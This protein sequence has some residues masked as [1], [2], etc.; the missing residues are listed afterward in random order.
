[1]FRWR[2]LTLCLWALML[3]CSGISYAHGT[4]IEGHIEKRVEGRMVGRIMGGPYQQTAPP[5]VVP[6]DLP[7][8]RTNALTRVEAFWDVDPGMGMATLLP[9]TDGIYDNPI[10]GFAASLPAPSDPGV[11]YLYIRTIEADNFS[12]IQ[13]YPIE[14]E[15]PLVGRSNRLELAECF[16][17]FDPGFGLG[18]PLTAQDGAMDGALE[19]LMGN[20]PITLAAGP[21]ILYIRTKDEAGNW[22]ATQSYSIE[23]DDALVGR[24]NRL[25]A[26]EYT[27]NLFTTGTVVAN[28]GSFSDPFELLTASGITAPST[29]GQYS[30]YVRTQD[31]EGNWSSYVQI[32]IMV[33]EPLTARTNRLAAAQYTWDQFN[34]GTVVANDGTFDDPLELI[35]ASGITA[36]NFS[37]QHILYVRTQDAEGTWSPYIRIPV[38]T[39]PPLPPALNNPVT[40]IA[41]SWDNYPM[42]GGGTTIQTGTTNLTDIAGT[43]STSGLSPG[44]HLLYVWAEDGLTPVPRMHFVLTPVYVEPPLPAARG[45]TITKVTAFWDTD[46]G[47]NN[48]SLVLP[49][50]S[51]TAL[52]N[53][54]WSGLPLPTAPGFHRLYVRVYN[55]DG[56]A[57]TISQPVHI[58]PP[59]PAARTNNLVSAAYYWDTD[60]TVGSPIPAGTTTFADPFAFNFSAPTTGLTPGDHKLYI[61]VTDADGRSRV[62]TQVVEID[63]EEMMMVCQNVSADNI[64]WC[65]T[66]PVS[67][68]TGIH[69]TGNRDGY[70]FGTFGGLNTST[71]TF[72][73]ARSFHASEEVHVTLKNLTSSTGG[74]MLPSGTYKHYIPANV[75]PATFLTTATGLT[76]Q[77][78]FTTIKVGDLDADGDADLVVF[79]GQA[80]VDGYKVSTYANNGTGTF[81]YLGESGA[82][83]PGEVADIRLVDL[84]NDGRLDLTLAYNTSQGLFSYGLTNTTTHV[85]NSGFNLASNQPLVQ[86]AAADLDLDGDQDVIGASVSGQVQVYV[87]NI[88]TSGFMDQYDQ[89][90]F[91]N[92][93]GI[94][95]GDY[96]ADGKMDL[97]VAG[98]DISTGYSVKVLR[99]DGYL[100]GTV[101]LTSIIIQLPG[102]SGQPNYMQAAD[103]DGDQD[104]DAVV[105]CAN[106]VYLLTNNGGV[107]TATAIGTAFASPRQLQLADLNGDGQ[108]DIVTTDGYLINQGAG[109]FATTLKSFD[110][111]VVAADIDGDRDVDF[112]SAAT[113][114]QIE[115]MT[116]LNQPLTLAPAISGFTPAAGIVGTSVTITGSNFTGLLSVTF[117]GTPATIGTYTA[118]SIT[119]QVPAGSATGRIAITNAAGTATSATDFVLLTDL[120]ATN[121]CI[122]GQYNN[123]LIP[124]GVDAEL[125]SDLTLLGNLTV[126]GRLNLK[127]HRASGNELIVT[128]ADATLATTHPQGFASTQNLTFATYSQ[129]DGSYE[130]IGTSPQVTG[131]LLP[132]GVQ[133]L[134]IAND[135]SLQ[136]AVTIHHTLYLDG[137]QFNAN[138]RV[139]TLFSSPGQTARIN[140]A[141]PTASVIN[142]GNFRQQRYLH[143]SLSLPN[144]SWIYTAA[145]LHNVQVGTWATN[146]PYA[147]YTY[148]NSRPANSSVWFYDNTN[149]DWPQNAGYTKPLNTNY[150]VPAGRGAR[151]WFRNPQFF[152]STSTWTATG[153]PVVGQLDLPVSYCASGCAN[154]SIDGTTDNGFNLVGNPYCST[155]DWDSPGWTMTN[156]EPT[157][158]IW[159]DISHNFAQYV[160]GIG[161]INGGNAL[162]PS[163]QGFFVRA[164]AANPVLRITEACKVVATVSPRRQASLPRLRLR[165]EGATASDEWLLALHPQGSQGPDAGLEATKM[166][167]PA[168]QIASLVGTSTMGIDVRDTLPQMIPL[169]LLTTEPV[170]LT[171]PE[172]MTQ[173]WLVSPTGQRYDLN[174]PVNLHTNGRPEIWQ[175]VFSQLTHL[176]PTTQLNF[177]LYPNPT[178]GLMTVTGL[179]GTETAEVYN[180]TG[181][182]VHRESLTPDQQLDL[183]HVS[184]GVYSVRIGGTIKMVVRE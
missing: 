94:A 85:I 106:G 175:L 95:A 132:A 55:E 171:M 122:G 109:S 148:D 66:D 103:L 166:R 169:R 178:T 17:D 119:V 13:Y 142:G 112:V 1:M 121:G 128:T 80:G 11:H 3:L 110:Q 137:G 184:P 20:L 63:V 161:G 32:P 78:P 48:E 71:I 177:G 101:M 123:V 170:H 173:A 159:Q 23:V 88:M 21:H 64:R 174:Q 26:A 102:G 183:R 118:T 157:I 35:T 165:M 31:A 65:F 167:G 91:T 130:Y 160:R 136:S 98:F 129:T 77:T 15:A 125:C 10:E 156:L 45:N 96:N 99:N 69:V 83:Y 108:L 84:N 105:S 75:A 93:Y 59:L 150:T 111:A 38:Y 92:C 8:P 7:I 146:N 28:D 176:T 25:A 76:N 72:T 53:F 54:D 155:I 34:F 149:L 145:G 180:S 152:G 172:S 12:T 120:V 40:R 87:N 60:P 47:L 143:S 56:F 39:E 2:Y 37:G 50:A 115:L 29:A 117:D 36:P 68:G 46:P 127:S 81:T 134:R 89:S 5:S 181:Q 100:G 140:Q 6:H 168:L 153:A 74:A 14:V 135:V 30:L 158:N 58:D 4:H 107:F 133:S 90:V 19:T 18:I 41:Y 43:I 67:S 24:S 138:N 82:F 131:N 116:H 113:T 147:V 86:L 52:A 73:P 141:G 124:A 57:T 70:R 51:Q 49:V 27:W 163:G 33:D 139:V 114:P 42:L 126:Q 44:Q 162:I 16:F 79:R 62:V 9:A 22:S 151:I 182:L 104:V 97:F 144:G 61:K 154:D 164:T 179:Q